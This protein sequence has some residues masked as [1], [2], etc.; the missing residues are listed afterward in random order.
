MSVVQ[1]T[2]TE[3]A[4]AIGLSQQAVSRLISGEVRESKRLHRI[5]RA[6]KTTPA[7]LE[8][9][10]DDPEQD[11]PPE[12]DLT[13]DERELLEFYRVLAPT[14][15]VLVQQLVRSLAG[16]AAGA[17]KGFGGGSGTGRLHTPKIEYFGSEDR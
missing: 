1:V 16:Q 13:L 4:A 3:L 10:V 5:A 9:E 17:P 14:E 6:L 11:A 2:Q 15:R 12:P 8:G 7:Y